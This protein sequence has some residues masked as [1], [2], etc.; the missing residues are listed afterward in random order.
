MLGS[1]P[2]RTP[3]SRLVLSVAQFVLFAAMQ[4]EKASAGNYRNYMAIVGSDK[5]AVS[6]LMARLT[7][8][9]SALTFLV[10]A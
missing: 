5:K 3:L 1:D 10:T 7:S 4:A 8:I 2:R 9:S 6:D